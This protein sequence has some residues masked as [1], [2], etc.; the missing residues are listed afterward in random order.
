MSNSLIVVDMDA[1]EDKILDMV[2]GITAN[3]SNVE[4]IAL[5]DPTLATMLA[6]LTCAA[7]VIQNHLEG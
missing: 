3:T 2:R 7:A 5:V 1:T 4:V 6:S